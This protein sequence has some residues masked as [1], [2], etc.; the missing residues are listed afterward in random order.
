MENI[1]LK[2]AFNKKSL[3]ALKD[4]AS[5]CRVKGYT[6]MKKDELVDACV[7]AV[8]KE[9]F[10]EEHAFI[11]PTE[12]WEFFQDIADSDDGLKGYAEQIE[13]VISEKLGFLHTEKCPEGKHFIIPNEIKSI[14]TELMKNGFGKVKDRADLIHNY[15]QAAVNLYGI[16]TQD[17]FVEIFNL[18]NDEKTDIEEIFHV[19]LKHIYLNSDYCLWEEYIV[20]NE[21]EEDNFESAKN[22]EILCRDKP[23][24]VPEKSEF[25]C[26]A[27][28]DYYDFSDEM[29]LLSSFLFLEL[30][31]PGNKID[32]VLDDLHYEFISG[33]SM[34]EYFEVLN[35]Y[36]VVVDESNLGTL[37][38]LINDSYNSTRMWQHKGLSPYELAKL[39]STPKR[40]T[41]ISRNDP[42]PCGSGKKYK[43]CCGR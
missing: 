24:Y 19:F 27:D 25:L 14:Y 21:F 18:Q 10:F 41:K 43:K 23:R 3:H 1:T 15:A 20:H 29:S 34:S 37:V 40:K 33:T 16:I 26:Y 36:N 17:E 35:K 8:Q 11:L 38:K 42:C 12:S 32:A 39:Q 4:I 5:V 9:G 22:L 6:K 31:V 28:Y 30:G 2:D 7:E 13:Y